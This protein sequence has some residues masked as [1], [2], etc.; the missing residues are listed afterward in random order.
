MISKE[1]SFI[2]K[3]LSYQKLVQK[4]PKKPLQLPSVFSLQIGSTDPEKAENVAVKLVA[5]GLAKVRDNSSDAA[6]LEAQETAKTAGKGVW[7]GDS[8]ASHVRNIVWETETPRQLVDRMG[9]KPFKAV[10]ESVRDGSTVRAFVHE[11]GYHHIT[12]LLSG[13]RVRI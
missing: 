12:L 6:L 7:S 9:G 2:P 1:N 8:P 4:V 5:E 3:K 10:I 13:V 11:D